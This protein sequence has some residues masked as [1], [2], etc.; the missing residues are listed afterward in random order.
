MCSAYLSTP[1]RLGYLLELSLKAKESDPN[2]AQSS[3]I[4][5]ELEGL[6]SSNIDLYPG[7]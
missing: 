3:P 2:T 1:S 7:G 4:V 5:A 6:A